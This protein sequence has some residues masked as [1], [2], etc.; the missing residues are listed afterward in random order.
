MILTSLYIFLPK[1]PSGL[2]FSNTLTV[3]AFLYILAARRMS[4]LGQIGFSVSGEDVCLTSLRLFDLFDWFGWFDLFGFV[5]PSMTSSPFPR[6]LILVIVILHYSPGVINII[7]FIIIAALLW[8]TPAANIIGVQAT[9][10]P[11]PSIV[12]PVHLHNIGAQELHWT[13]DATHIVTWSHILIFLIRNLITTLGSI[14]SV[15]GC[16][17]SFRTIAVPLASVHTKYGLGPRFWR[18][19]AMP[20]A[21]FLILVC[22]VPQTLRSCL[23]GTYLTRWKL[24]ALQSVTVTVQIILPSSN[25]WTNCR[26]EG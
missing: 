1:F 21:P 13:S 9:R 7:I 11:L 22:S 24:W 18:W 25:T 15:A 10:G 23:V 20:A 12:W 14:W 16:H 3:P 26:T 17:I 6:E 19:H 2:T 4:P 5:W 8:L